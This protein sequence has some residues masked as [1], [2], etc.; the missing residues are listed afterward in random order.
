MKKILICGYALAALFVTS[1]NVGKSDF[2]PFE[3]EADKR[4]DVFTIM[5]HLKAGETAIRQSKFAIEKILN[6]RPDVCEVIHKEGSPLL[7]FTTKS[8]GISTVTLFDKAEEPRVVYRIEV[9]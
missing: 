3:S 8:K 9:N 7:F 1:C 6:S 2:G 5:L 4:I